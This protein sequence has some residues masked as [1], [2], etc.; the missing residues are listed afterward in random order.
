MDRLI[1]YGGL[2]GVWGDRVGGLSGVA[3]RFLCFVSQNYL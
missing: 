2:L 1:D 3:I